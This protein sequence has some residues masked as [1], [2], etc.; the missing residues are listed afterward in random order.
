M[1]MEVCWIKPIQLN[2]MKAFILITSGNV[3]Y[4]CLVNSIFIEDQLTTWNFKMTL[5]YPFLSRKF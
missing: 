5:C 4:T 3:Y 2:V 1:L